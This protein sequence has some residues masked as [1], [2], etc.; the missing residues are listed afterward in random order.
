MLKTTQ[1]GYVGYLKDKFTLLPETTDRIAAT[2]ISATWRHVLLGTLTVPF[3]EGVSL[4][5]LLSSMQ[6]IRWCQ[7]KYGCRGALKTSWRCCPTPSTALA[8][9]LSLQP[10]RNFQAYT[11][12]LPL[13]NLYMCCTA[14]PCQQ[15]TLRAC[16]AAAAAACGVPVQLC[17][18]H[19]CHLYIGVNGPTL[20]VCRYTGPVD[21]DKAFQE[22][23]TALGEAF[24]GPPKSGVYSPSVQ[25]TLFQMAKLALQRCIIGP[26]AMQK[27]K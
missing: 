10:G 27:E 11:P 5:L 25:Y 2:S 14:C 22:I 8:L 21:Y 13:F 1:S 12:L 15:T 20:I 24:W 4:N 16:S 7:V 3:H 6:R 18:P 9:P 26:A 23:K 19:L 17:R